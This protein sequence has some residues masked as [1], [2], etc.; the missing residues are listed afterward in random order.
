M[1]AGFDPWSTEWEKQPIATTPPIRRSSTEQL[2]INNA[3]EGDELLSAARAP[4]QTRSLTWC[5]AVVQHNTHS[6]THTVC[7][8]ETT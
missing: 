2:I 6:D 4:N 7:T 8:E 1:V 5:V 3:G